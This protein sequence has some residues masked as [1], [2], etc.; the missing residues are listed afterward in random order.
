MSVNSIFL[1]HRGGEMNHIEFGNRLKK[2]SPEQLE[3]F[4]DIIRGM[5][6]P[7]DLPIEEHQPSPCGVPPEAPETLE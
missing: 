3:M 1:R 4:I 5:G 7:L 2:L 6:F